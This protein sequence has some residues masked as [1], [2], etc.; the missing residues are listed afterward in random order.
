[1]KKNDEKVIYFNNFN[2]DLSAK[3]L[4]VSDLIS[5]AQA[6]DSD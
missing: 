3:T 2:K 1:M 4:N 5:N 6:V